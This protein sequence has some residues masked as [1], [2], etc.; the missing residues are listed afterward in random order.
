MQYD[1]AYSDL[2]F[3]VYYIQMKPFPFS[4]FL[5]KN[6]ITRFLHLTKIIKLSIKLFPFSN[7]TSSETY[8][9]LIQS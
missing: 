1:Y 5:L 2:C 3:Y 6:E 8:F 4:E 9:F 7:N